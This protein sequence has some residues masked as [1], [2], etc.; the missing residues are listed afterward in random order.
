M[1]QKTLHLTPQLRPQHF[2]RWTRALDS[3]PTSRL[4]AYSAPCCNDRW[5]SSCLPGKAAKPRSPFFQ[6][7]ALEANWQTVE[8]GYKWYLLQNE[9]SY[10]PPKKKMAMAM[11]KKTFQHVSP[12]V[13]MVIF[14]CCH[15]FVFQGPVISPKKTYSSTLPINPHEL[16][17]Y[18]TLPKVYLKSLI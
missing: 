17:P 10:T 14:S 5:N 1:F 15:L 2:L 18:R 4:C 13:K 3:I 16:N 11:E 9:E 12:Y 7:P 6:S 8:N